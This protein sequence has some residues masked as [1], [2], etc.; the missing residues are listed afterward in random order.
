MA[1]QS[2]DNFVIS[3]AG[4]LYR[5]SG[6]D[7]LAFIAANVGTSEFEVADLTARN[8]LSN[9]SIGDRIFVTDASADAN[10][11]SGWAIYIYRSPGVFTRIA[12]E[13]GLDVVAGAANLGYTAGAS[14]GI[15]TSSS[16]TDATLPAADGTNAGLMLP[17]Q[18]T[19]LGYLTATG[20]INLDNLA[21]ASHAA[22]TVGGT[23]ATNPIEVTGQVLS[24]NIA[25]LTSAP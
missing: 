23:A 13:E 18:F 8:A 15:V 11:T 21:S 10:V 20:A 14:Q 25:A 2:S 24:F 22:V 6:S 12:E 5:L 16:G 4:T 1:L 7:V 17:A 19:K 9:C 3:R